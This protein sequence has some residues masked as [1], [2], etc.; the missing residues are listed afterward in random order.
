MDDE[1]KYKNVQEIYCIGLYSFDMHGN[2]K[3]Y[4][5]MDH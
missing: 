5:G 1:L 4:Y 2:K 3:I